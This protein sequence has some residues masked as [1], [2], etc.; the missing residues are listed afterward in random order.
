MKRY[1]GII[2]AALF[3]VA[4]FTP[5][6]HAQFSGATTTIPFSFDAGG[7][8]YA[9]GSYI[10]K[11][12]VNAA[13]STYVSL[14]GQNGTSV[15]LPMVGDDSEPATHTYLL[16][17]KH[18]GTFYLSEFRKEDSSQF[19]YFP[20]PDHSRKSSLERE[21]SQAVVVTAAPAQSSGR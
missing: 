9:A 11:R 7:F 18:G 16:F 4:S 21:R 19:L 2:F 10:L 15:I 5:T 1:L 3:A 17:K 8:H 20:R 13:G 6:A 12:Q 14:I